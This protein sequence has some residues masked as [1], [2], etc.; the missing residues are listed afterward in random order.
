[1]RVTLDEMIASLRNSLTQMVEA[2]DR[3]LVAAYDTTRVLRL[4]TVTRCQ[5]DM[6]QRMAAMEALII[7]VLAT[8]QPVLA[9][10]L[11]VVKGLLVASRQLGQVA[12][13]LRDLAYLAQQL[14]IW[15]L[16]LPAEVTA[17][18]PELRQVVAEAIAAFLHDDR[19][20]ADVTV[21]RVRQ[22]ERVLQAVPMPEHP[23][24]LV[25]V[26]QLH[27]FALRRILDAAQ[28]IA[29]SAPIY[30]YVRLPEDA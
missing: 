6:D 28:E 4:Q 5:Q 30:R 25:P 10:D 29:R 18:V 14:G 7:D 13:E 27:V 17:A 21:E 11:S 1:M 9:T 3:L 16:Q 2:L 23:P 15:D 20:G 8:Q 24:T 12:H 19:T 22:L 26:S